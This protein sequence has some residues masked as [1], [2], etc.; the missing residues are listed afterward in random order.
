MLVASTVF[1][2]TTTISGVKD[3]RRYQSSVDRLTIIVDSLYDDNAD[4]TRIIGAECNLI[5]EIWSRDTVWFNENIVPTESFKEATLLRD[6]DWED[7][8][9]VW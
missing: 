7:T 5:H 3:V 6:N 9:L 4:K 2:A 1:F 8:F